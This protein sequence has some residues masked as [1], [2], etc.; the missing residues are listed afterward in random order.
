MNS[1]WLIHYPVWDLGALGGGFLIALMATVHVYVSHFAV[2]GGL[3]LVL[4]ERK[5]VREN[6][7][8]LL[9]YVHRHSR[10]FLLLTMVFGALTGVGIWF[11]I[12]LL[13]PTA[14]SKLI[15]IFVFAFATEWVFFL[16][17]IISLFIYYYTFDSMER[18]RHM[19]IG[20]LYALFAFLSLFIINGIIAFMLTP[21][22]WLVTQNFWHGFFNPTFWPALFFRTF[23]ALM[24]AG[25]FGLVTAVFTREEALQEILM[26]Y[27]AKWVLFPFLLLMVAAYGYI[28]VLPEPQTAVIFDRSPEIRPFLTLFAAIGALLFIVGCLMMARPFSIRR[29]R[30][31]AFG[32][33]IA[34]FFFMGSFEWIREAGRRPYILYGVTYS[35]SVSA[36]DM[37]KVAQQGILASTRWTQ[38]RTIGKDNQMAVGRDLFRLMC[39]GCHSIGGPL[40]DIKALTRTLPVAGMA[41]MLDGMGKVNDYMPPFPGTE[42]EKQALAI[43]IVEELNQVIDRETPVIAPAQRPFEQPLFHDATDGYVLLAW[44]DQGMQLLSD[45]DCFFSLTSPG[46]DIHAQLVR[47]GEAPEIVSDGVDMTY[48]I[49]AGFETPARQVDYWRF[50]KTLVGK[51]V[52]PNMGAAGKSVTDRMEFMEE[53]L[54]FIARK[55]PVVPYTSADEFQPYP[56]IAVE[57]RDRSSGN[58]LAAT[59]FTAAVSTEMGCRHCHGGPW[60]VQQTAGISD[61]TARDILTVHDRINRTDLA[62]RAGDGAP[63]SCRE[64]HP[65]R[66]DDPGKPEGINLSAAI[67][68]FHA[69]YMTGR[70]ADACVLCHPA[71]SE[72]FT[73]GFRGIHHTL[74]LDCT[75]CHARMEDHAIG[76]LVTELNAAKKGASRLMKNLTPKMTDDMNKIAAR[77]PWVNEP[78]CLNC[79]QEFQPPDV[80]QVELN[81]WTKSEEQLFRRR[82]D[83]VG[84]RCPACHGITHAVYPAENIFGHNRDTV[85]PV[86]YQGEAY[87]IGANRNCKTCHTVDMTEEI[88]HPNM[89]GMFRNTQ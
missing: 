24:L 19:R 68:G 27:C 39:S 35:N 50:A 16:C 75:N 34:G 78:D 88:H 14:T 64:C 72:G 74:G 8:A 6:S 70:G 30:I 5:A 22:K 10:F 3:F 2:G 76:L 20:W 87:P 43:Y 44:S 54:S 65:S 37:E 85:Q 31:I 36:Q 53:N 89:L 29:K 66:E 57:A 26:R 18:G 23:M 9:A 12:S 45:A 1:I 77:K 32:L 11:T 51:E 15:H 82:T 73:R 49:E 60:R 17:E 21:G 80:D 48:R 62:V 52:A 56:L 13:N 42:E 40:Q 71:S 63:R 83:E 61:P 69:N 28:A 84:L 46:L 58:L 47:R 25:I 59:K 86:Q 7:W 67:H 79:H 55:V 38:R 4:T 33:L 81:Q 41:A